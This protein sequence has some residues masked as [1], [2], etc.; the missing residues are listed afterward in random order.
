MRTKL[1]L[2]VFILAFAA[3]LVSGCNILPQNTVY[4]SRA[5]ITA[6]PGTVQLSWEPS[7]GY[8]QGY[9]VEQS[10]DGTDFYQIQVVTFPEATVL[11]L[12]SGATYYF[13]VRSFNEAGISGYSAVIAAKVN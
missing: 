13:R 7:S 5:L 3:A 9:Y 4:A 12:P 11:S 2:L 6:P 1:F 10:T 8:P